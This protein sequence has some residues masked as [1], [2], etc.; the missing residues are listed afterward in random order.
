MYISLLFIKKL[1]IRIYFSEF[2]PNLC[3][4]RQW[5]HPPY[6]EIQQIM[7][8]PFYKQ[9]NT[10]DCGPTCLK[11]IAQYYGKHYN[12]EALRQKIGYS[13][14]GVSL[15]GISEMAEKIGFRTRGVQISYEKL[16]TVGVPSI[17]HWDQNH[18]IVL[19]SIGRNSVEV[20]DP[21]SRIISYSRSEFLQHWLSTRIEDTSEVGTLLLLEPTSSFY[22]DPGEIQQQYQS[23]VVA[24]QQFNDYWVNGFY[25]RK[26]V[27]L[28][29]DIK[30]MNGANETIQSEK[31]LI[32]EDIKLAEETYKMNKTLFEEKVISK[33]EFRT[34]NSKLINKQM[35]MPQLEA[36]LFNNE[37]LKRD[38]LKQ[39]QQLD[40]D[41][42]Q[43]TGVFQQAL[44]SLK[45]IIDD[46]KKKFILQAPVEGKIVFIIPLQENQYLSQEKLLGYINPNGSEF[47][48]EANLP[49][50]NFGKV[51]IG[52]NVQL[53]FDAYPYQE[54]GF[55]EGTLNYISNVAS[56]SGF[57]TTIR[58]SKGLITNNNRSIPYKNG[59][60]AQAIII[61]K[62]MRLFQRLW[63]DINKSASVG[64]K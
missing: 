35:N 13:K 56:D 41:L 50:A 28:E 54:I 17:L 57:L 63:Y 9:L 37:T 32:A 20:A 7:R 21:A 51:D 42:S 49:Q 34:E 59:L 62:N 22:K 38:K 12:A 40:H 16:M 48:A 4:N 1:F 2:I 53:R 60:K 15:L 30:S 19:V 11:M 26:R 5:Q 10:M 64:S 47:Y 58:L 31:K 24:L 29:N 36:S 27:M 39:L 45:S 25:T 61:T 8:F 6:I 23:F 18:F 44:Q 3:L 14:Q 52:L 46:W 33:E 43:E 55:V